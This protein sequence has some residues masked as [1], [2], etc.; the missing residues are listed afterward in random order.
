MF[1]RLALPAGTQIGGPV[2]PSAGDR[3]SPWLT[4]CS[5]T[6]RARMQLPPMC[7]QQSIPYLAAADSRRGV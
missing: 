5:G 2:G 3:D 1:Q 6:W 4:T 7:C